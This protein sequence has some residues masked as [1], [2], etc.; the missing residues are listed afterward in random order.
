MK[1]GR[2]LGGCS[3]KDKDVRVRKQRHEGGRTNRNGR[4]M[5]RRGVEWSE[6]QM[7][8]YSSEGEH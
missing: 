6:V 4:G 2:R 8:I 3:L 1:G 7:M 5:I